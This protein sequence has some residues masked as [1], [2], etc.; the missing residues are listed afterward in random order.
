VIRDA[1]P[2]DA[3]RVGEVHCRAREEA[4]PAFLSADRVN[5][6]TIA[7]RQA[8]WLGFVRDPGYGRDRFLLVL[9]APVEGIVGFA[10]AGPQRHGDPAFPGEV[11]SI[12]LLG[13]HRGQGRG[14]RLMSEIAGRLH[15]AGYPALIVWTQPENLPARAF[16]ERL[17]GVY[18]RTRPSGPCL[19][20]AYGWP[21]IRVLLA[22]DAPP[23][24]RL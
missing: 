3:A 1:A 20:V 9:E 17:G 5:T 22:P 18:V 14:R 7:E 23:L 2:A 12:Y 15:G 4:Y 10:G 24:R 6:R 13:S 21:D 8:Q 16:Y 11:W 19:T